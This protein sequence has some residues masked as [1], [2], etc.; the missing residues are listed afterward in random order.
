MKTP[1]TE[2]RIYGHSDDC[3][4]IDG[5]IT[6][7]FYASNGPMYLHFDNRL[8]VECEYSPEDYPGKWRIR[9]VKPSN[10]QTT[11]EPAQDDEDNNTDVLRIT[12][13]PMPKR[14]QCWSSPDG[15]CRED[16]VEKLKKIDW[17]DYRKDVL[18]KVLDMLS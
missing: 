8:V 13:G 12:H 17:S 15:P 1:K 14:V 16:L 7:E 3:I 10:Y 18:Q 4:E 2:I 9:E 6:E 5:A 11:H